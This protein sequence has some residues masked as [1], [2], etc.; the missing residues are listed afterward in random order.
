[1]NFSADN[2]WCY[3]DPLP[4]P[5]GQSLGNEAL[6]AQC[7]AS[8]KRILRFEPASGAIAYITCLGA[9]I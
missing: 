4:P 8:D 5:I 9:P 6:V 1:V 3:V 7:G 2:G